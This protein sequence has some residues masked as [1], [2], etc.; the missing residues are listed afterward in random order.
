VPFLPI[1]GFQGSDLPE[2]LG[3]KTVADPYGDE[4]L[5]AVPRLQPDWAVI[6]VPEADAEGN[7]RIYGTP[8]WDRLMTRG[9]RR[10]IVTAE[11]IVTREH[12][13]AQPELTAIPELFVAA[14]VH[15]PGGG[16]PGS[17]FP[18][19]EVDYAA[20]GAY[21]AMP[22]DAECLDRHLTVTAPRDRGQTSADVTVVYSGSDAG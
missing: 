6:H 16:W 22:T 10:V 5:Y 2:A 17:C 8:F 1:A 15:A 3:W 7:A 20:A 21:A 4:E 13:A 18:L 19:Y 9:A 12:L 14:V 11:T